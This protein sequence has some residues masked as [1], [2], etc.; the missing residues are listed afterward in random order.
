MHAYNY[1]KAYNAS[2][3]CYYN[4]PEVNSNISMEQGVK[5]YKRKYAY[6]TINYQYEY[7]F[8]NLED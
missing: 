5:A 3:S 7:F 1:Y 2:N 4:T 6:H 8:H